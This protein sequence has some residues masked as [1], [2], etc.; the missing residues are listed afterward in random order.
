[1][2]KGM[3]EFPYDKHWT[4]WD[5]SSWKINDCE[6]DELEVVVSWRWWMEWPGDYSP[7]C[8]TQVFTGE[9]QVQRKHKKMLPNASSPDA[10]L[11][12][13]PCLPPWKLKFLSQVVSQLFFVVFRVNRKSC[14][15]TGGVLGWQEHVAK[16]VPKNIWATKI[17]IFWLCPSLIC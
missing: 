6:G 14:S 2:T 11:H 16:W 9:Q 8:W 7:C 13:A 3:Q 4:D 12:Q 10:Q 1:M 5:F 17:F 15:V